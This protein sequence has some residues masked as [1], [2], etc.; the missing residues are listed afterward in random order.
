MKNDLE[1]CV[2]Y[3]IESNKWQNS[4]VCVYF[5]PYDLYLN[6]IEKFDRS[7]FPRSS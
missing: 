2:G 3:W 6:G 7:Q 1:L 4:R 5:N